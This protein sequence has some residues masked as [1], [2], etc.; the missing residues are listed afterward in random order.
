MLHDAPAIRAEEGFARLRVNEEEK[1]RPVWPARSPR[2]GPHSRG[3][4]VAIFA[5]GFWGGWGILE[6]SESL[7]ALIGTPI[8]GGAVVDEFLGFWGAFGNLA[9]P[10]IFGAAALFFEPL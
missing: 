4:S 2:R 9:P 8:F 5:G 7:G 1:P 3:L 6:A 10:V